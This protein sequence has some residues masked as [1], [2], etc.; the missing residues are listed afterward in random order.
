MSRI[1]F[2]VVVGFAVLF[3]SAAS[4]QVRKFPRLRFH[5]PGLNNVDLMIGK[6]LVI[7]NGMSAVFR[8]GLLRRTRGSSYWG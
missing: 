6:R 2:L 1:R 5:N 8:V 3:V 7:W 4:G